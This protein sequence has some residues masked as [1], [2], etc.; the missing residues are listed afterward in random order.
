M[1]KK[2]AYVGPA[3]TRSFTADDLKKLE[4]TEKDGLSFDR[5]EAGGVLEVKNAT[6]DRLVEVLPKEFKVVTDEEAED[7][8]D[9]P[10]EPE[11]VNDATDSSGLT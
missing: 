3:H 10:N 6:A 2:L 11:V 9:E 4:V 1:T 8:A 7:L 5:R